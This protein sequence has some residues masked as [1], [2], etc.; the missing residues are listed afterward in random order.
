MQ[1]HENIR[2]A[3]L[4]AH[5]T[6][7]QMAEK[8]GIKRST[9]QYWEKKTPSLA[10]IKQVA[11]AL[12]LDEDYFFV[13]ADDAPKHL[14]KEEK[15]TYGSEKI[16]EVLKTIKQHSDQFQSVNQK[17]NAIEQHLLMSSAMDKEFQEWTVAKLDRTADPGQIVGDMMQKAIETMKRIYEVDT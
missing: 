15:T 11:K 3:R 16:D 6:E 5:L 4:S 10:K 13:N 9:Y 2:Q 1:I 7:E 14:T 17:L 12:N 8:L